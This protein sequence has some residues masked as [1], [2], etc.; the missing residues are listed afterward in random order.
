MNVNSKQMRIT[1]QY[2]ITLLI[3]VIVAI[4]LFGVYLYLNSV[5]K[6]YTYDRVKMRLHSEARTLQ[7]FFEGLPNRQVEAQMF[8]DIADEIGKNLQRRVTIIARNGVVLGDS[9]LDGEK[10]IR[11][12]NH[13][14]RPSLALL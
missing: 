1:I 10:L 14:L 4:I 5:L 9:D 2:K 13:I 12:D 3:G 6:A 8:D 7:P 11:V